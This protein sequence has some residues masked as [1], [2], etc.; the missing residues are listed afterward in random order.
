MARGFALHSKKIEELVGQWNE[1]C[2]DY[3][4]HYNID[5]LWKD[6]LISSGNRMSAQEISSSTI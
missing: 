3:Q 4:Y 5:E 6:N 2:P 1:I